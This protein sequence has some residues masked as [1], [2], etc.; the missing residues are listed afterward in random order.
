[1]L[2]ARVHVCEIGYTTNYFIVISVRISS[3]S[4]SLSANLIQQWLSIQWRRGCRHATTTTTISPDYPIQQYLMNPKKK[5]WRESTFDQTFFQSFFFHLLDRE[6]T[7]RNLKMRAILSVLFFLSTYVCNIEVESRKL[8]SKYSVS[9][10]E[11]H[12]E[13]DSAPVRNFFLIRKKI[14]THTHIHT[15]NAAR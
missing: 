14:N 11:A 12:Q 6:I 13:T 1:M 7:K 10:A 2:C 8:R 5:S 9:L 4:S 15:A 3:L